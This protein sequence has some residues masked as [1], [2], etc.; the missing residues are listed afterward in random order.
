MGDALS[1]PNTWLDSGFK[2]L[3]WLLL[4]CFDD[5]WQQQ[6]HS[7]SWEKWVWL[8][9]ITFPMSLSVRETWPWLVISRVLFSSWI[10]FWDWGKMMAQARKR[11]NVFIGSW[12]KS[13]VHVK[14]NNSPFRAHGKFWHFIKSEFWHFL[15]PREQAEDPHS[16]PVGACLLLQLTSND[17]CL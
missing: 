6:H 15:L 9:Q 2:I 7:C 8:A 13:Q 12:D 14:F 17:S 3:I 1:M 16:S 4:A 11:W 5:I 10:P